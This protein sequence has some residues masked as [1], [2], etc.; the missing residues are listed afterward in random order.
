MVAHQVFEDGGGAFGNEAG[1]IGDDLDRTRRFRQQCDFTEMIAWLQ[2]PQ[3]NRL[4]Y[5]RCQLG[6]AFSLDEKEN[7]VCMS[8]VRN[9][10]LALF[11]RAHPVQLRRQ[12]IEGVLRQPVQYVDPAQ[13]LSMRSWLAVH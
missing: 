11:L 3:R 5:G 9:D 2:A 8:Q 12:R 10:N 4:T 1:A 6:P 13:T 7:G